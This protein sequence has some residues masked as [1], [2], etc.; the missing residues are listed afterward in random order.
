MA[1]R[2]AALRGRSM[3]TRFIWALAL[4]ALALAGCGGGGGSSPVASSSSSGSSSSSSGSTSSS[5]SSGSSSSGSTTANVVSMVVNSGPAAAGGNVTN[6]AYVSI[7]LCQP[8]STTAC[9]TIDN[10]Q[11]DT[12]SSGLRVF[13]SVLAT[14]GLSLPTMA[15]PS[16]PANSIAECLAFIDGYVWGPVANADL[17]VGG[18]TA[19]A[20]PLH[21][22]NDNNS[23][24]PTVPSGCTAETSNTNLD[25]IAAFGANGIIGV[26]Y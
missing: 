2:Q 18:E 11:V 23:Y 24:V 25:T 7:Q 16:A 9:A 12:G 10:I 20:M 1:P 6:I 26:D 14:A 4:A 19:S 15:D 21:I 22:L 3:R 13:A 5:S 8:G 17:T